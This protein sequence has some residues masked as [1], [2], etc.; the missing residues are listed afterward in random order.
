MSMLNGILNGLVALFGNAM[1][2]S[3]LFGLAIS[4][5][6]T[7]WLKFRVPMRESWQDEYKWFVRLIAFPLGFFPTY[8][9]WPAEHKV[10]VALTV[11]LTSPVLYKIAVAVLYWKWPQLEAKLSAQPDAN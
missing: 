7:Q 1:A 9:T 3:I 10:W 11:A 2:V 6:G 8:Y 5:A 4:L